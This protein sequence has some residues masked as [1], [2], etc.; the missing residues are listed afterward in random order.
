MFFSDLSWKIRGTLGRK[1]LGL[2]QQ[3]DDV[4]NFTLGD[5]DIPTPKG[6]CDAAVRSIREH[7]TRFA[8]PSL[9]SWTS[10]Q[11]DSCRIWIICARWSRTAQ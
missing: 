9:S 6:I 2:A 4:I 8:A 1:F 5:P 11:K 10:S 7:R 3:Y